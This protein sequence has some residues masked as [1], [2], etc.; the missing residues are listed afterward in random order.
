LE[1][2]GT[3]SPEVIADR[4]SKAAYELSLA[5]RYDEIIVN[6]DLEKAKEESILLINKFITHS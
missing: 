6:D 4:I 1:N 3:D 2:R 5:P